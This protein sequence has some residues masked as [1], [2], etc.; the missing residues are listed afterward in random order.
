MRAKVSVWSLGLLA[1]VCAAGL[2]CGSASAPKGPNGLPNRLEVAFD[3]VLESYDGLTVSLTATGTDA[4]TLTAVGRSDPSPWMSDDAYEVHVAIT[5]ARTAFEDVAVPLE[6]RVQGNLQYDGSRPE[7]ER[8]T[9]EGGPQGAPAVRGAR[10]GLNCACV[11]AGSGTQ[12]FDGPLTFTKTGPDSVVGTLE[13]R[14][15]GGVL[16]AFG[17][18]DAQVVL[19]FDQPL[20]N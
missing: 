13:L 14:V 2:A 3:G 10:L 17:D 15:L 11:R 19:E 16:N 8:L 12:S 9:W 6:L 5:V 18:F 1:G 7:G 4:V 20:P